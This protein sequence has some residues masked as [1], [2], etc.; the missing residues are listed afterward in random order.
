VFLEDFAFYATNGEAMSSNNVSSFSDPVQIPAS[1]FASEKT[2]RKHSTLLHKVKA[3]FLSIFKDAKA[4]PPAQ[5]SPFQA[6]PRRPTEGNLGR[7]L[8][9]H[10]CNDLE[11]RIFM[12]DLRKSLAIKMPSRDKG[13]RFSGQYHTLNCSHYGSK[14]NSPCQTEIGQESASIA[15]QIRQQTDPLVRELL[16][17]IHRLATLK[18]QQDQSTQFSWCC[19][20]IAND[21]SAEYSCVSQL[22]KILFILDRQPTFF[23]RLLHDHDSLPITRIADEFNHIIDQVCKKMSERYTNH[24]SS[25]ISAEMALH[26]TAPYELAGLLLT[27]TG[28]INVGIIA[29]LRTIFVKNQTTPLNYEINILNTLKA[30][31]ESSKLRSMIEAVKKPLSSDSPV[32]L[33]IRAALNLGPEE[34]LT[35]HHARMTVLS[36]LLSHHRQGNSADCFAAHLIEVLLSS[37]NLETPANDLS[38]LIREGKLVRNTHGVQT[39]LPFLLVSSND[40]NDK[41]LVIDREGNLI[42]NSKKI[43]TFKELDTFSHIAKV[44]GMNDHKKYAQ[45]A[46]D[47]LFSQNPNHSEYTQIKLGKA[48]N[49]FIKEWSSAH[50]NAALGEMT[51]AAR[52]VASAQIGHPLLRIWENCVAGMVESH[53]ETHLRTS[54]AKCIIDSLEQFI[55]Q[56]G[57]ISNKDSAGIMQMLR[58]KIIHKIHLYYDPSIANASMTF[59]SHSAEGAFVLYDKAQSNQLKSWKWSRIDN[60][61]L[62]QE[63]V[64]RIVIDIEDEWLMHAGALGGSLTAL[65]MFFSELRQYC[66]SLSFIKS[67]M[68]RYSTLVP[69][70]NLTT[71]SFE[72]LRCAPW[73]NKLGHDANL[74][75]QI[76]SES[77]STLP[78]N[79]VQPR[80][81]AELF[82][83]LI[84][85]GRFLLKSGEHSFLDNPYKMLPMRIMNTHAFCLMPGHPTLQKALLAQQAP[86]EWI[87]QNLQSKAWKL[88]SGI[89]DHDMYKTVLTYA[90]NL[91]KQKIEILKLL[92]DP[93]KRKLTINQFR[94]KI[95]EALKKEFRQEEQ[96]ENMYALIDTSIA[97]SLSGEL[98][99][100][101]TSSIIH[102]GNSN[103]S[104][105]FH[106]VH[107]C[108]L[109]NPGTGEIEVWEIRDDGSK[110][111]SIPGQYKLI[112]Q[113]WEI[114]T[115]P[116]KLIKKE[117]RT[118]SEVLDGNHFNAA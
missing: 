67:S 21:T 31:E 28:M 48:I 30:L 90:L 17:D 108:F 12:S 58:Q 73:M 59:D 45:S 82:S 29:N 118:V 1:D 8:S 22:G 72:D 19:L 25:A 79:R 13:K 114:L 27:S 116:D 7:R 55:K 39:D 42:K 4:A 92:H 49:L 38:A 109:A 81:A 78:V 64:E 112:R 106:D 103:W 23:D 110:P 11:S 36:A 96:L 93:Y 63:F 95:V 20:Q 105:D 65:K 85:Y 99:E 75:L 2:P 91:S 117:I 86:D 33:V 100:L 5:L 54:I 26:Q 97:A 3:C 84:E 115:D 44:L 46:L 50:S 89:V 101:F 32:N 88:T 80:N 62:F 61:A 76:Y 9:E 56:Y 10:D 16:T 53:S 41:L 52:F 40:M 15:D 34:T 94:Q 60:P 24:K 6:S 37:S 104:D 87:A 98:K 66:R 111:I 51:A 77:G 47:K 43:G 74:V 69:Y 57:G 113:Q 83:H 68:Q 71:S 102:F 70:V 107:F 14:K 18:L 35:D